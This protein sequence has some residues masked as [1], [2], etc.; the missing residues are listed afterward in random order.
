MV[1]AIP[2]IFEVIVVTF[3]GIAETGARTFWNVEEDESFSMRHD[4]VEP[5]KGG[6]LNLLYADL[7]F[8]KTTNN[9]YRTVS[10]PQDVEDPVLRHI[11]RASTPAIPSRRYHRRDN[12]RRRSDRSGIAGCFDPRRGGVQVSTWGAPKRIT[13][14][15]RNHI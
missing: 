3:Q 8:D 12:I 2:E 1:P 11:H 7:R 9:L 14:L 13:R 15:I 6:L 10:G 5:P 4:H